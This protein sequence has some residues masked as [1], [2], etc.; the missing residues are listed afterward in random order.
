MSGNIV[1]VLCEVGRTKAA[2]RTGQGKLG[3]KPLRTRDAYRCIRAG[4]AWYIYSFLVLRALI[5]AKTRLLVLQAR[6]LR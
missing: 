6:I 5:L 2:L 3:I 1:L 4:R